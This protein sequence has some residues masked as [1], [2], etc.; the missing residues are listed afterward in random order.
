MFQGLVADEGVVIA[1]LSVN[2][3]ACGM[4]AFLVPFRDASGK[5]LPGITAEDMGMKTVGNDL[6]N[7]RLTFSNY[8]VPVTALLS[9]YLNVSETGQVSVPAAAKGKK[10]MEFIGQ[11]LFTGRVAVAQ[12]ALTFAQQYVYYYYFS[13]SSFQ[14]HY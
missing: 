3:R 2:G 9:R 5:L 6:D 12:A 13:L 4:Q 11:R 7:A 14:S 1:M 10:T 8:T